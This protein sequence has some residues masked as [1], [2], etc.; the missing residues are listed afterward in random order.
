MFI[1]SS[2]FYSNS[3]GYLDIAK[4]GLACS[5]AGLLIVIYPKNELGRDQNTRKNK[6]GAV[7]FR[8]RW[9]FDALF[10]PKQEAN[11]QE[12]DPTLVLGK[13]GDHRDVD[14]IALVGF[15]RKKD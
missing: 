15:Y 11:R 6:S 1:D 14:I 3:K 13:T 10:W 8:L 9:S 5:T 4:E 2:D 12:L 7:S